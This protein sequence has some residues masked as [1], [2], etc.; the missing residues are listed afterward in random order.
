MISID[1]KK[2]LPL[3]GKWAISEDGKTTTFL[4][5]EGDHG[6]GLAL[7]GKSV[8][9]GIIEASIK[10]ESPNESTGAFIV[11][12]ASGQQTYYAA[13]LG[14]WDNAYTLI[15][16]HHLTPTRLA[17]SGSIDNLLLEKLTILQLLL[18]H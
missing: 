18:N 1:Y 10:I 4:D 7:L 17:S 14:G 16:G 6:H 13:G 11:F 2:L 5:V 8:D 15:E 9:D 12:R 3:Y